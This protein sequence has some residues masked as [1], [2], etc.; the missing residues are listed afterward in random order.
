MRNVQLCL[1]IYIMSSRKLILIQYDKVFQIK[2]QAVKKLE[3]FYFLIPNA[4]NNAKRI[5]NC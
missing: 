5:K 1:M 4:W 2:Y 3:N